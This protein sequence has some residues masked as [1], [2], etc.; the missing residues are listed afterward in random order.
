MAG[1]RPQ[2]S[3]SQSLWPVGCPTSL[4]NLLLGPNWV[5]HCVTHCSLSARDTARVRCGQKVFALWPLH[6]EGSCRERIT[7][8]LDVN[9]IPLL[10]IA[11]T[12]LLSFLQLV[13]ITLPSSSQ[14]LVLLEDIRF[15]HVV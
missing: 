2:Y 13:K 11:L 9:S 6:G 1:R 14:L 5:A 4:S 12:I 10:L 15:P 8:L 3:Y 7:C